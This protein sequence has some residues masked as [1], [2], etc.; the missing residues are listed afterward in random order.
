MS[1][2]I[3]CKGC[4]LSTVPKRIKGYYIGSNE[5]IKVWECRQCKHLWRN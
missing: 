3:E 2:K 4:G 5:M 1:L